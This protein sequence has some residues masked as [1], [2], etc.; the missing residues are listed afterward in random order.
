MRVQNKE[1]KRKN[2]TQWSARWPVIL[3]CQKY[4][5]PHMNDVFSTWCANRVDK[6]LRLVK[7]FASAIRVSMTEKREK[8]EGL[9]LKHL[10]ENALT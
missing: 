1:W 10:E 7:H 9:N 4:G 6:K 5:M 8:F 2:R 3:L